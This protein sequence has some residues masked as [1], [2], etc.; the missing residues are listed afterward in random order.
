VR[1]FVTRAR[2]DG[3]DRNLMEKQ[4]PLA[5][6]LPNLKDGLYPVV[7]YLGRE[8]SYFL[9]RVFIL[10]HNKKRIP[11]ISRPTKNRNP[12]GVNGVI[13]PI[14]PTIIKTTPTVF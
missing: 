9:N 13:R 8:Y 11:N 4:D 10:S 3:L 6:Y 12:Q 14:N 7:Q 2:H 1:G 5:A